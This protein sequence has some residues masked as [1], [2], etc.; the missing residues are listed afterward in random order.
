MKIAYNP[1]CE[2]AKIIHA[3][4]ISKSGARQEISP[5]EINVMDQGWNA[6]AKRYTGGKV[7]VANLPGVEIGSTIEV[8]FEITMH[9]MPFLSG[10]EPFQFP[11]ALD[12]KSFDLTAP[13]DVTI[14]KLVSGAKGIVTEQNKTADGRTD[15]RLGRQKRQGAAGGNPIAAGVEL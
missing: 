5:G 14:H 15:F 7:L 10:F 6:G 4:V 2:D 12:E 11:D 1:A 9:D 3:V 13:E 8:E